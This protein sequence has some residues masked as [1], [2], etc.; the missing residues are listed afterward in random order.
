[1]KRIFSILSVLGLAALFSA[2]CQ[3]QEEV[4]ESSISLSPESE[5]VDFHPNTTEVTVTSSGEWTLEGNSTW[6]T[7]SAKKGVSGDKVTFTVGINTTGKTRAAVYTFSCG[8]KTAKYSLKQESGNV[9]VTMDLAL[10]LAT[11]S[12]VKLNLTVTSDDLS[13][14]NSWGIRY[15]EDKEKLVESGKDFNI[16]GAPAAGEK[17]VVIDGLKADVTYYFAAWAAMEDG[18]RIYGEDV[19]DAFTGSAFESVLE[20]DAKSRIASFS[21]EHKIS[22][23]KAAGV[24]W[25]SE[26]T[27]TIEGSKAEVS[28]PEVGKIEIST[29]GG[30]KTLSVK[31]DYKAC[32]YIIRSN[33][34][35]AYGPA[36]SFTTMS[37]P[38]DNWITDDNF[39]DDYSR[40][41]SLCE[42]GPVK[43][44]S[45]G[46]PQYMVEPASE[47][48]SEFRTWWNT[49]LTSYN[50]EKPYAAM[51]NELVFLKTEG[52]NVMD[53]IVWR[54]GSINEGAPKEANGVGGFSYTWTRDND[55]LF[56]FVSTGFC[57]VIPGNY[58]VRRQ[59][60]S[61]DE[62]SKIWKKASNRQQLDQM[63]TF[64]TEHKFVLDWGEEFEFDGVKVHELMLYP[65][66]APKDAFK[67]HAFARKV[68][69]YDAAAYEIKEDQPG[70]AFLWVNSGSSEYKLPM[71]KLEDGKYYLREGESLAGKKVR[72]STDGETGYPAFVPSADGKCVKITDASGMYEVPVANKWANKC[73]VSF[74]ES[75][76]VCI[77][78]DIFIISDTMSIVGDCIDLTGTSIG[79]NWDAWNSFE[80]FKSINNFFAP[81]NKLTEPHIYRFTTKF[82]TNESGEGFKI[83][84]D[85]GW[86]LTYVAKVSGG[87]NPVNVWTDVNYSKMTEEDFKWKPDVTG[88]Y[89]IELDACAMKLRMVQKK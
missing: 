49:A 70:E 57:Y 31:T 17:E 59:G 22:D 50:P 60:M 47:K 73:A 54:E 74:S 80:Y 5:V 11:D 6:A 48:Q 28:N 51:F 88:E 69:K 81:D 15:S 75:D 32:A 26:G 64:W 56:S 87:V 23:L 37:D 66:D 14:F 8:G 44:G 40:F 46:N 78:K 16:D 25:A 41:R 79:K 43:D 29:L 76:N 77:V 21:F 38:F 65:V 9:R 13:L 19:I 12:Q 62:I 39:S 67:F 10:A 34:S 61:V 83:I 63:R 33:G 35:V 27:P 1:M 4:K 53:N 71:E 82:V 2:G 3:K 24:C 18:T 42:Y 7:P 72:I 68:E 30:G 58:A 86:E 52:G 84:G 36:T 85:G 20:V 45:W 55:G 89:T